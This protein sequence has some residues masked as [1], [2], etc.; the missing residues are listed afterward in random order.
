MYWR[1]RMLRYLPR[2]IFTL[3]ASFVL[4]GAGVLTAQTLTDVA[5]ADIT[6]P[7]DQVPQVQPITVEFVIENL[8]DAPAENFFCGIRIVDP[9]NPS[10]PLFLDQVNVEF[11]DAGA[12]QTL[13]STQNW[14]PE[15]PGTY[16]V[17]VAAI[18]ELDN[19]P[20]NNIREKTFEIADGNQM[21]TLPEAIDILNGDVLDGHPRV[22]Q[23]VALHLSPPK[24]P[25][26]SIVP[27]GLLIEA[28]DSSL[29]LQYEYPVYF[30]FVDLYPDELYS[31]PVEYVAIN[32]M[33]GDIDRHTN[34]EIWPEIDGETPEF[35]P[36]CFG[37]NNPRRV[38]G[39]AVQCTPKSDEYT[40]VATSD[41]G[42]WAVAVVGKLNLDVEK[43]TVQNDLCKW[44]ERINGNSMGPRV[45]GPN[46]SSHS[47][48][49]NCGLTEQ[50]LCDAI[51]ALKGKDCDKI[52]FKYVGH[53][54]TSGIIVW[55]NDHRRSKTISWTD[56]ACKLKDAGISE[57]CLEITACH[58]GAAIRALRR[59]G[60]RGNV[61]TS[62]SSGNTTPVGDGSGTWWEK[63]LDE[64]SKDQMADLNRNGKIDQCELFA[65]VKARG[66]TRA[67]GPNPQIEK[68]ND[69]VAFRSVR[70]DQVGGRRTIS[71]NAGSIRVYAERICLRLRIREGNR[72]RDSVVYRGAIY[73]E[74][75]G[76]SRRSASRDYSISAR[77]NR[78][79][80]VLVPRIRP[81]L[82][83]G[84]KQCI[85][86]LPDNCTGI[87]VR[88]LRN[89]TMRDKDADPVILAAS[90]DE[91]LT[92]S[93]EF[94][95][96]NPGDFAFY[97][98]AYE[99]DANDQL[100]TSSVSG[101]QDWFLSVAPGTFN[102]PENDSQDVFTGF[103][104]PDTAT[105]GG[106]VVSSLINTVTSDTLLLRYNT[107]VIDTIGSVPVGQS[108]DAS[109]K[110]LDVVGSSQISG[111]NVNLQNTQM[112][113]RDE[114][115]L[116]A[117]GNWDL[118][119]V[120]LNADSGMA[121]TTYIGDGAGATSLEN[122]L[123]RGSASGL[124]ASAGQ[125][126]MK[127]VTVAASSGIILEPT[128]SPIDT[129]VRLQIEAFDFVSIMGSA[130]HGLLLNRM[131]MAAPS[132]DTVHARWL[133]V[134]FV[135]SSAVALR[136]NSHLRCVDCIY[137]DQNVEVDA[138]SSLMRYGTL[139]VVAVDT[140][141]NALEGV[142]VVVARLDVGPPLYEGVTDSDGFIPSQELLYSTNIG[143]TYMPA[144]PWEV[145]ASNGKMEL[146]DTVQP[147][148]W[149]QIFF[150]FDEAPLSVAVA[151][152]RR[153]GVGIVAVHPQPSSR[154]EDVLVQ[155][156][157]LGTGMVDVSLHSLTG[158]AVWSAEDV[159]VQN[160]RLVL[161]GPGENARPGFY[162][163]RLH[164]ANGMVLSAKIL[165]R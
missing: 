105:A 86:D 20:T 116:E 129:I 55:D 158:E 30:F 93:D 83:P 77:C 59:K 103:L 126:A 108:L 3:A 100:Y 49:E 102:V 74:N 115:M 134:E 146:R 71:T 11:L 111:L 36:Y 147:V 164:R 107:Y 19:S 122:V 29:T 159:P 39:G 54:T 140:A 62:S 110:W 91:Y 65:W 79:D 135:D 63:A 123:M 117:V 24:N 148:T 35:G 101:P 22:E 152:E 46:I 145:I 88:R 128:S 2:W 81:S 72:R 51:D 16:T 118:R 119:D 60:I 53:G 109:W 97:R 155:T 13:S 33:T 43:T 139:S 153:S 80:T 124:V 162:V 99:D 61:I 90:P 56:F 121:L 8:G 66:G 14:I 125:L 50:E 161:K 17:Q 68:L 27:A 94:V 127:S 141:G 26:D 42:A 32:A 113:V 137:D 31:H 98:F 9:A 40:P 154:F 136:D 57:I 69:S 15:T 131:N 37:E 96:H 106:Q 138:T 70:V 1:L 78:R 52:F 10:E 5:V 165:L 104:I 133:R 95:A 150:E 160:D 151:G 23:L 87:R 84:E 144:G 45:T 156:A 143:G 112:E 130:G 47:G 6:L 163:L 28:A 89:G 34:V 132:A 18:F 82:A 12:T 25:S 120:T 7:P 48:R 67:N 41:T 157:G 149:T 92:S 58:S 38:R 114:L 75:P 64:C 44:K 85:A 4:A 142:D 73:I 21:L 76:N